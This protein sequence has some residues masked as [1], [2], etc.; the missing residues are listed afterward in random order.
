M[1]IRFLCPTCGAKL[2][3]KAEL[4]GKRGA[5]PKCQAKILIP[6]ESSDAS[7]EDVAAP[8]AVATGPAS[9]APSLAPPPPPAPTNS[10]GGEARWFVRPPSGG[11]Y[12]PALET[13]LRQWITEGRITP[14]T[15]I[16]REGDPE[17]QKA[18]Q[19]FPQLGAGF[20]ASAS[21]PR[22]AAAKPSPVAPASP[23]PVG[24]AL[25]ASST[26]KSEIDASTAAAAMLL[27]RRKRSRTTALMIMGGLI[28]AVLI[29]LPI[30]IYVLT[31]QGA[32]PE[33]N[34]AEAR[35]RPPMV[36]MLVLPA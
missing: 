26:A 27:A 21:I 8:V 14:D 20:A 11:Q 31:S 36:D 23:A 10:A 1:G 25:D 6:T 2:N 22:P 4:A 12:G 35:N 17:W 5:C 18:S 19:A 9:P 34:P 30:L 28:I 24:V 16:W 33:E 15:L 29:L 7:A 13:V 3:V 32:P